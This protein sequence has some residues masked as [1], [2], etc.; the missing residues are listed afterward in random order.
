VDEDECIYSVD[1]TWLMLYANRPAS[2]TPN[3]RTREEFFQKATQCRYVYIASYIHP[4]YLEF[5]PQKYLDEGRIV[6]TDH[7]EYE[8]KEFVLG[9]LV[10][11]PGRNRIEHDTGRDNKG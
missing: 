1:P 9:M 7:I 6:F 2:L 10:E 3:A 4:P 8:G 5:Y 11:M